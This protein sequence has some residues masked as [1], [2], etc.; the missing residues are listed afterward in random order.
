[1]TPDEW[2]KAGPQPVCDGCLIRPAKRELR[3][4][5]RAEH[6]PGERFCT[7]CAGQLERH[8]AVSA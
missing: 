4:A 1:M 7:E 2:E 3:G 6:G 5:A 8:A